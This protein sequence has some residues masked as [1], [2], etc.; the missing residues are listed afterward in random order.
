MWELESKLMSRDSCGKSTVRNKN[1]IQNLC[2]QLK[3]TP[4]LLKDV[5]S[6][7][8]L[9]DPVMK[10]KRVKNPPSLVGCD[11]DIDNT[12]RVRNDCRCWI[13]SKGRRKTLE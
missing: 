5:L 2:I 12:Q 1:S 13:K 3:S 6:D 7:G 4:V 8:Q 10:Y 11:R 9:S